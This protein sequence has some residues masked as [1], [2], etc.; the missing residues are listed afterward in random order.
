VNQNDIGQ[1]TVYFMDPN[2]NVYSK[3][4]QS[5]EH[6]A[7]RNLNNVCF[8]REF[9]QILKQKVLPVTYQAYQA[10]L[11]IANVKNHVFLSYLDINNTKMQFSLLFGLLGPW[12]PVNIIVKIN[13]KPKINIIKIILHLSYTVTT[14]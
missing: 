3:I 13:K 8:T 9:V 12:F 10:Y 7:Q 2:A 4:I 14:G 5:L 11:R 1:I 6:R